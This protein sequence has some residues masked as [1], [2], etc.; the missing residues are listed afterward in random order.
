MTTDTGTGRTREAEGGRRWDRG[1]DGGEGKRGRRVRE[2][3]RR[4]KRTG[5]NGEGRARDEGEEG[6]GSEVREE[7]GGES[8]AEQTPCKCLD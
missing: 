5:A 3:R 1:G 7:E 2:R 4:G 6:V 8:K